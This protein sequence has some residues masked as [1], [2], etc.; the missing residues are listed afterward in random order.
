MD[1]LLVPYYENVKM[2][3]EVKVPN[4]VVKMVRGRG[5][6][7]QKKLVI[8]KKIV[9]VEKDV[10]IVKDAAEFTQKIAEMRN[11][12]P[13][14]A[15]YRVCQDGGGGSFKTVV[16]VM[17]RQ[18]DPDT[19]TKGEMLSG[20]NRLLPLAVCPGIPERHHNLRQI[21]NHLKLHEIP[22]LKVI[23]DLCLLNAIIGVSSHGGKYACAFCDGPST[24]ESGILRTFG[25]L[26]Q[27][28]IMYVA[29]GADPARMKDFANVIQECLTVAGLKT[30][31]IDV[32]P[33]PE[34][35]LLIGVVNHLVKLCISVDG[36]S[37]LDLLKRHNIFRHGYQG[38]GLDGNNSFK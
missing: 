14:D 8:Q 30:L 29:A 20:V 21:M 26:H 1:Q 3:M 16:S 10:A 15:W 33:L 32:H 2:M 37:I 17:D 36:S 4:R 38:G 9:K 35:H 11:I 24:L 18:V 22:G 13:E 6:K 19:E 23:M 28:Y 27:M 31:V 25:H 34:L 5:G 7:L 12:S